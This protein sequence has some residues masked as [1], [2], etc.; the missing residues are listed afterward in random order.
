MSATYFNDPVSAQFETYIKD[1]KVTSK[2]R[3]RGALWI[4]TDIPGIR[5]RSAMDLGTVAGNE[6]IDL[7]RER[8]RVGREVG[9][10]QRN[11]SRVTLKIRRASIYWQQ[12]GYTKNPRYVLRMPYT[13]TTQDLDGSLKTR[14]RQRRVQYQ[15]IN[16]AVAYNASGLM[17]DSLKGRFRG[18][19]SYSLPSGERVT[20]N[21][22]W[23]LNVSANRSLV[24]S[25]HAGLDSDGI[26]RLMT[27]GNLPQTFDFMDD[28]IFWNTKKNFAKAAT[29]LARYISY[30]R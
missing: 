26:S 13:E 10:A 9:G 15:V 30:L 19:R 27:P 8:W 16:E 29:T 4:E 6:I 12:Q 1:V 25:Q 22:G 21:A 24:A 20:V 23:E 3:G 18:A 2:G 17:I 7:I 14:R 5:G 28:A 11:V